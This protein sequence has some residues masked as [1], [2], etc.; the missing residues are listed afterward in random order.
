MKR[1]VVAMAFLAFFALGA[2]ARAEDK[3]NPTGTWKWTVDFG[4]QS[5]EMTLKLKMDGDK[6]TGTMVGRDGEETKIE[7][8]KYKDGDVSFKVTRKRDDQTFVIKYSGKV[9]GDTFKG[10]MEVNFGGEDR[11]FDFE[12]K[13]SKDEKKDK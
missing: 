9:T 5:R 7:D 2:T 3:P 6:L 12:A 4:G 10:K 1:L 8:A 11:S 13:R